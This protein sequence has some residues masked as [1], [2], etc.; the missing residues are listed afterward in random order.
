MSR[1]EKPLPVEMTCIPPIGE[2]LRRFRKAH[3]WSLIDMAYYINFSNSHLSNVEAGRAKLSKAVLKAYEECL[4]FKPHQIG[5]F[6]LLLHAEIVPIDS[7]FADVSRVD[8]D[9]AVKIAEVLD[10]FPE[11]LES[12]AVF[13]KNAGCGLAGYLE[14]YHSQIANELERHHRPS[15]VEFRLRILLKDQSERN[16]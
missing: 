15:L 12:V 6:F 16:S 2:L 7:L 1:K 14:S 10:C 9:K 3:D 13:I 8:L 5:A 11:L 4:E